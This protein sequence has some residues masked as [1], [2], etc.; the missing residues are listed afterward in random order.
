MAVSSTYDVAI[1]GGGMV[2][3]SLALALGE[4]LPGR[5]RILLAESFPLPAQKPDFVAAYSPSFDARSTALS[6]SSQ[7]IYTQMG[8]WQQLEQRAC[9]IASIHVSEKGRFGSTLLEA[10]DYEWPAL[11]Y[12]IENAWLGNV[13]VQCLHQRGQVDL[14]S[15]AQV[16]GVEPGAG[17][18]DLHFVDGG[19]AQCE[20]LVVADGADSSLREALGIAVNERPYQQ[21]AVIAN[22]SHGLPHDGRAYERFTEQGPLACLPLPS[23]DKVPGD[24]PGASRRS[25]LVWSLPQEEAAQ[26][27]ACPEAEFLACLQQRF[28]YRLGR[29]LRV[30]ERH[31]YPLSL[32]QAEEQVRSRVVVIGNAAHAL[33]PVAGQGFNLALRDVAKL[34]DVL[35]RAETAGEC[36]FELDC[37]R[38]YSQGQTTDQERTVAFSDRLPALFT[39]GDAALG[40]LRDFGLFALD[41]SPGL[42]REFVQQTAGTAAS[43]G[44]RNVRP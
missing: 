38:R 40:L 28:G 6:Y 32:V 8:V 30:G 12:V 26:M 23:A 37:L 21:H 27:Q 36:F 22:I 10:A 29:M 25:A 15:P 35:G 4:A 20:L 39:S 3:V 24:A 31:S 9:A 2:G 41:L 18:V 44:Y 34:A 1:V 7:L 43:A 5:G 33:H 13:L 19:R 42:K 11:G 14:L 16:N 17:G